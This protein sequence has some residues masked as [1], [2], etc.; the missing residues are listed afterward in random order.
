[1]KAPE[2]GRRD[3]KTTVFDI[4]PRVGSAKRGNPQ[5]TEEKNIS[6]RGSQSD[7]EEGEEGDRRSTQLGGLTSSLR[8]E[9]RT[10]DER[11]FETE[12]SAGRKWG[13]GLKRGGRRKNFRLRPN[14]T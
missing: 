9:G 7:G 12:H 13:P 4:H 1:V 3:R 2:E 14:Q 11:T 5:Q 8:D 6:C 10:N